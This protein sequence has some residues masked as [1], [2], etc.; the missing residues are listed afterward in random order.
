MSQALSLVLALLVPNAAGGVGA[1]A[2]ASSVNTWYR[3]LRKPSWQPPGW[4]FGPVWTT[5]YTLMGIASWLVSRSRSPRKERALRL[6][7]WQLGLNTLWSVLFFGLRRPDLALV[8]IV[9]LW[10]SILATLTNFY[11]VNP[12]AGLLLL[13]YQL[14]TTFA[15]AL[16]FAIWRLNRR[17]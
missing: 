6:Y 5:L 15:T 8:E 11:R 4:L 12:V 1:L 14:W 10:G 3:D 9:P 17:G 2:T 16:N 7:G 13:P